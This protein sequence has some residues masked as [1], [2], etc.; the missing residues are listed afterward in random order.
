MKII[1]EGFAW[2]I[3]LGFPLFTSGPSKS[4]SKLISLDPR[5]FSA[6]EA[7]T[8]E[9]AHE[10]DSPVEPAGNGKTPSANQTT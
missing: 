8:K 6:P 4:S 5:I 7:R 3:I 9:Q 2:L 1:L 10:K